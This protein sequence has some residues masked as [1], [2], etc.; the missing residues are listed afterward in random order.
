MR[1][2]EKIIGGGQ[3]DRLAPAGEESPEADPS[4]EE[5]PEEGSGGLGQDGDPEQPEVI[6]IEEPKEGVEAPYKVIRV[7]RSP[8]QKEI[9]DHMATHL[10]HQGWCEVCMKG[11]GRNKP[12][13]KK[14]KQQ[15]DRDHDPV[16]SGPGPTG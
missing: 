14:V 8:T 2:S 9:D 11:R 7:P 1:E 3:D 16:D 6:V 15:S 4:Q 10:P 5:S 12:H 13:K